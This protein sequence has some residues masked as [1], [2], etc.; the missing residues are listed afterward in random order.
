M[1]GKIIV[2]DGM[3]AVGKNTQSI[4]LCKKLQEQGHKVKLFSFPNYQDD[5]SFFIKKF[6]NGEYKDIN[7]PYTI[8][9]FYAVDRA[10]TFI[11]EIK[12]KYDQG[13]I[14]ILDRYYISSILYQLHNLKEYTDKMLYMQYIG[15]VEVEGN[16]LP[17]PDMTIILYAQPEVSDRL[18]NKRYDNDDSKRDINENI[19][20]QRQVYNNILFVDKFKNLTTIR[21][22]FGDIV[23]INISDE[24][25]NGYNIKSI[26]TI[27][28][29]IMDI[30]KDIIEK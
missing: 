9:L 23:T 24:N 1:K 12:E 3:D 29:E 19:N 28:D 7:N 11:R 21:K 4:L 10:I 20:T 13:Y 15:I 26:N 8:S 18:L 2:I 22:T 30:A 5:S 6:L 16:K 27:H 14:I 25:Y 17:I